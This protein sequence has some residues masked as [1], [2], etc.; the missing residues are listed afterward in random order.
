[1]YNKNLLKNKKL[2][3]LI[4][5]ISNLVTKEGSSVR[6]NSFVTEEGCSVRTYGRTFFRMNLRKNLLS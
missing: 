2:S 3:K 5:K 1:M 4:K 6:R